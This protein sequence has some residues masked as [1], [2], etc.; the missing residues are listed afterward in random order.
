MNLYGQILSVTLGGLLSISEILPFVRNVKTNGILHFLLSSL[1]KDK[2]EYEIQNDDESTR[3]DIEHSQDQESLPLDLESQPLLHSNKRKPKKEQQHDH[4]HEDS[5]S[6]RACIKQDPACIKQDPACIKQD[7]KKKEDSL[8]K[9]L[10]D[11]INIK[12]EIC[13]DNDDNIK[14]NLNVILEELKELKQDKKS[15]YSSKNVEDIVEM[16]LQHLRDL[17]RAQSQWVDNYGE[18]N[19]KNDIKFENIVEQMSTIKNVFHETTDSI[20]EKIHKLKELMYESAA[21]YQQDESH[22]VNTNI[23]SKELIHQTI[24]EFFENKHVMSNNTSLNTDKLI[25]D[26]NT[27]LNTSLKQ[28]LEIQIAEINNN[29]IKQSLLIDGLTLQCSHLSDKLNE[30]TIKLSDNLEKTDKKK[31]KSNFLIGGKDL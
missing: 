24:H 1:I 23:I 7:D 16:I 26:V 11:V 3:S 2:I 20:L 27:S 18:N 14:S 8:Q 31:R 19:L 17:Q 15:Y 10:N 29:F 22:H 5:D 13:D 30:L 25:V 6:V 9:L 28:H 4:E 12:K 21:E